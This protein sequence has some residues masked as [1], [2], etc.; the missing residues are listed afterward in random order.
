MDL[1]L[2]SDVHLE[3]HRDN[4]SDFLKKLPVASDVLVV[5]G[6]LALFRFL[7]PMHEQF[8]ALCLNRK[9]VYYVLGNH[10]YYRSSPK[11]VDS[12]IEA[13]ETKLPTLRVLR[14]GRVDLFEGRRVLGATLWFRD[15]PMNAMYAPEL[16]DFDL[17]KQF[18]PWV[19]EQ[20]KEAVQFFEKELQ[21]DDIVITHH[22]PSYRSVHPQYAGSTLNRFFVCD[23]EPLI[24]ERQPALWMHG[25]THTACDYTIEKC[26]VVANP[27]GYPREDSNRTFNDKL[28]LS[29]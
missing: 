18:V 20:N 24:R 13:V 7:G 14:P 21:E 29:V 23:L 4:G 10:E 22:L 28:V 9:R 12:L 6:D 25:H 2:I 5:A 15:D 16:N 26:R 19:Y 11:D 3:F 27:L 1:Q 17:I 8:A